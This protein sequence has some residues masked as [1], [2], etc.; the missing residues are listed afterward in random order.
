MKYWLWCTACVFQAAGVSASEDIVARCKYI[1]A[2]GTENVVSIIYEASTNSVG[3]ILSVNGELPDKPTRQG[4]GQVV[5]ENLVTQTYPSNNLFNISTVN[6]A[7]GDFGTF[8][9]LGDTLVTD[10]LLGRC[11]FK[12]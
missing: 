9:I 11:E 10:S 3:T 1:N 7:T 12:P 6:L 4:K 2:R 5:G 8:S